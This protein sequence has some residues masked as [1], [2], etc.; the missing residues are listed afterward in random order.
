[1]DKIKLPDDV[2]L[3]EALNFIC[4][5]CKKRH[6]RWFEY[7]EKTYA[8]C[9]KDCKSCGIQEFIHLIKDIVKGEK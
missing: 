6:H 3:G 8:I 9:W 1:M 5:S 2:K 7:K 4:K